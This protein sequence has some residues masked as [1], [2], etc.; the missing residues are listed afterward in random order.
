MISPNHFLSWG[1]LHAP[2][3]PRTHAPTHPR[4]HAPTH[5][6]RFLFILLLSC[7]IFSEGQAQGAFSI[8]NLS[9]A[10]NDAPIMYNGTIEL[11]TAPLS[12]FPELYPTFADCSPLGIRF[13][14][15]EVLGQDVDVTVHVDF[16]LADYD[17]VN[18]PGWVQVPTLFNF[19]F[20]VGYAQTVTIPGNTGWNGLDFIPIYGLIP[21]IFLKRD[22]H[23]HGR[24]VVTYIVDGL[25]AYQFGGRFSPVAPAFEIPDGTFSSQITDPN[26]VHYVRNQGCS[27]QITPVPGVSWNP[28]VFRVKGKFTIDEDICFIQTAYSGSNPFPK[29]II[30]DPGAEIIVL[31]GNTLRIEDGDIG[32]C[33]ALAQGIT[34]KTGATLIFEGNKISDCRHAINAEP[35][36][37]LEIRD[38]R[39]EQNYIGFK[40]EFDAPNKTHLLAFAGNTFTAPIQLKPRF[41]GMP[42]QVYSIGYAGVKIKNYRDFNVWTANTFDQLACGIYAQS[43]NMNLANQSFTNILNK[44]TDFYGTGQ[45]VG[46]YSLGDNTAWMNIGRD[47]PIKFD[48]CQKHAVW[49][50]K[51]AG[52]I[53][54]CTVTN[55]LSGF[56]WANSRLRSI[57]ITDNTVTVSERGIYSLSNEPLFTDPLRAVP[58]YSEIANNQIIAKNSILAI[59]GSGVVKKGWRIHDNNITANQP[60]GKGISYSKGVGGLVKENFIDLTAQ[61]T[62]G[63]ALEKTSSVDMIANDVAGNSLAPD[64][65]QTCYR[66][67]STSDNFVQ[68]NIA[69]S[70][71]S[72]LRVLDAHSGIEIIGTKMSNTN[73]GMEYGRDDMPIGTTN[74]QR[75]T[76]NLFEN[77]GTGTWEA[78]SHSASNGAASPYIVDRLENVDFYPNSVNLNDWFGDEADDRL[79]LECPNYAPP[80]GGLECISEWHQAVIDGKYT[81]TGFEASMLGKGEIRV[82]ADLLQNPVLIDCDPKVGAWM[83]TKANTAFGRLG[84]IEYQKAQL[85]YLT[86]AEQNTLIALTEAVRT[87]T[88]AYTNHVAQQGEQ[89]T[90]ALNT[91]WQ[92]ARLAEQNHQNWLAVR[93][94]QFKN[95]AATLAIE[96]SQIATEQPW[97]WNQKTVNAAYFYSVIYDGEIHDADI[98]PLLTIAQACPLTDGDAVYEAR[99]LVSTLGFEIDET[100]AC[101]QAK[102]A[103]QSSKPS[104]QQVPISLSIYPNPAR[105]LVY[106]PIQLIGA[107]MQVVNQ[108]GSL[109]IDQEITSSTLDVSLLPSGTYTLR[110]QEAGKRPRN[111][112]LIVIKD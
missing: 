82:Y 5:R 73:I 9:T 34:V 74:L 30:L 75:H 103:L 23:G 92:A 14:A 102:P 44:P 26:Y 100:T 62:E 105:S 52:T 49:A 6:L 72:G 20:W 8:Q 11:A 86:P 83:D 16:H 106:L 111:E 43:C 12:L 15:G 79:T 10:T 17:V 33:E 107:Q 46:I 36:A 50:F 80:G 69:A 25:T 4:T 64:V 35:D 78:Y 7:F 104:M 37:T 87:N 1:V 32:G 101:V 67:S 19:S 93:I 3:H 96:N 47:G 22:Q 42:E 45:G 29:T 89:P 91:L 84:Q 55:S 24:F 31:G 98:A 112:K 77:N 90:T 110:I 94:D 88:E 95:M 54:N 76:G 65:D 13:A 21:D 97:E 18:S 28:S 48:N 2:T 109:V 71:H 59:E 39:F 57:Q 40:A 68:C 58:F 70:A 38:N 60:S 41:S 27:S 56:V 63:I 53:K 85:F 81:P 66:I 108:M 61:G 51:N 99:G